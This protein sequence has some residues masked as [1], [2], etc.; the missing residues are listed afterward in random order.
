ML[1][2]RTTI[3]VQRFLDDLAGAD[4]E[5]DAQPIIAALIGR[6]VNRL[7]LLCGNLLLRA[8]PRLTRPPLNLQTEE[9]LSALVERLLKA[10][11]EARPKNVRQFFSLASQHIR[12]ELN[13]VARRLDKLELP[14]ELN[15]SGIPA[16]PESSG[17]PLS[18]N[19]RR[20]LEAI[21]SLPEEEREAFDLLRIQGMT[22]AEA[23]NVLEISVRTLQRRLDRGLV[24]LAAMLG[25]LAPQANS[26]AEV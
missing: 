14:A 8:Y 10:M 16:P 4:G 25:D 15:E 20:M 1:E 2:D 26:N 24:H 7:Q 6:S 18:V 5:A 13:D 3:A 9:M 21:E 23:A 11:R 22:Q 19:G 12:W 17:S